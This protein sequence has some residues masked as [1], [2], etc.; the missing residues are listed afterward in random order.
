MTLKV[1]TTAMKKELW[2]PNALNKTLLKDKKN[3]R[4]APL[5]RF[6]EDGQVIALNV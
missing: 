4:K 5:V 3:I 6:N 1:A 2:K